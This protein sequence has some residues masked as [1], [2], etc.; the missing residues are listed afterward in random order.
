MQ[1]SRRI[2]CG[3]NLCEI[4]G[5]ARDASEPACCAKTGR[6]SARTGCESVFGLRFN[7]LAAASNLK[8]GEYTMQEV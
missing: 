6:T 5:L 4:G 1:G 8:R 7:R 2:C 3:A